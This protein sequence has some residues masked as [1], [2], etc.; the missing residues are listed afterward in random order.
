[1]RGMR[2]RGMG[3]GQGGGQ[4]QEIKDE[5]HFSVYHDDGKEEVILGLKNIEYGWNHLGSYYLSPDSTKVELSNESPG[6][7]VIA[8]AVKWVKQ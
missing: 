8:D 3:G 6:R 7:V 2:G 4:Q 1:M 5:Y